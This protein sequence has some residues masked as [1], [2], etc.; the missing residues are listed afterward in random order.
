MSAQ[1]F[2]IL[3]TINTLEKP[4]CQYMSLV[5]PFKHDDFFIPSVCANLASDF[6]FQG[7]MLILLYIDSN[8]IEKLHNLTDH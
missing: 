7:S 3:V 2:L 5:V 8:F 6:I 4:C 1:S